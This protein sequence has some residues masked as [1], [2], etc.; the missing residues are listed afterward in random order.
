MCRVT[1]PVP[2]FAVY[3]IPDEALWAFP[4]QYK[5]GYGWLTCDLLQLPRLLFALAVLYGLVLP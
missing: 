1:L 3:A 5:P 4:G 2:F